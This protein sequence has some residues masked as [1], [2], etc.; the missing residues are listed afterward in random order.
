VEELLKEGIQRRK[1]SGSVRHHGI[2]EWLYVRN[3]SVIFP[4]REGDSRWFSE[5]GNDHNFSKSP[6]MQFREGEELYIPHWYAGGRR[7]CEHIA[8]LITGPQTLA[9]SKNLLQSRKVLLKTF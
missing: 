1:R 3:P 4:E 2:G 8:R 7:R 9:K 5:S 6:I